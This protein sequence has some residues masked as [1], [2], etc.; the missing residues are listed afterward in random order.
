[1]FSIYP[2]DVVKIVSG[3][4]PLGLTSASVNSGLT[5]SDA[6][7]ARGYQGATLQL[8]V[9]AIGG[10][11]SANL[12]T[13][14]ILHSA[15]SGGAYTVYVD[16]KGVSALT[17]VTT[18]NT[19]ALLNV[20]LRGSLGFLKVRSSQSYTDGTTP[21]CVLDMNLILGGAPNLPPR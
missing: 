19:N 21:G 9:G 7:D 2:S 12:I 16:D 5:T 20:D 11:A 15:T 14:A 3:G 8:K 1:M 6:I 10:G 4:T 18:A 13:A 17:T